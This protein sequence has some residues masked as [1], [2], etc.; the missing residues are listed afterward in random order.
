MIKVG[1][2][3]SLV[4]PS[5]CIEYADRIEFIS[6][7]N[8]YGEDW[9]HGKSK[10]FHYHRE[11]QGI[12][13]LVPYTRIIDDTN[14]RTEQASKMKDAQQL[15]DLIMSKLNEKIENEE[16]VF[17]LEGFAF[18]SQGASFIDLIMYNCFLRQRIVN[19]YGSDSL[20]IVAPTE[21]KRLLFGKGN[22]KKDDMINSFINNNLSDNKIIIN[23]LWQY[24]TSEKDELDFKNIK[25]IDDIVDS[26]GIMKCL[27]N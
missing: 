25:P 13:E 10:K 8:D 24:L 18:S 26:Y 4:S 9:I 21:A 17:S 23:K 12:V 5:V 27:D 1:I 22:A 14:Y 19:K 7:F 2:D 6:F 15:A 11:L 16:V 3:F 20:V